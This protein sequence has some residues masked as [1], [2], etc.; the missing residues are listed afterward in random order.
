MG[1]EVVGAEVGSVFGDL[2]GCLEGVLDGEKVGIFVGADVVGAYEGVLDGNRVV[3][4]GVVGGAVVASLNEEVE[5]NL[6]EP[7]KFSMISG[8][9]NS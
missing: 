5:L 2:V 1:C 6:A 8:I 7:T 3:G 9:I 4:C